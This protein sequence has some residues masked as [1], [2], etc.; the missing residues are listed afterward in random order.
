M[1]GRA[2][3][4]S[5]VEVTE[6]VEVLDGGELERIQ[7][8]MREVVR[9]ASAREGTCVYRGE[10][11]C[12]CVVSSRLYRQCPNSENEAF[13]MGRVEQEMAENARQYTTVA[14]DGEILTEIQYFGGA[15]NLID[16]T[17]DYLVAL[18]FASV[19]G[20]GKDGR[21]VLHWPESETMV[22]PKQ[23]ISRVV[24]QK[25][26]FVRP[27]RGFIVPDA[28]DET[29]VVPGNLKASLLS[30]LE[31]F[32]GISERTVYNDIHGF[33]GHQTPS[34]S[35]YAREFPGSRERTR[36]DVRGDLKRCLAETRVDICVMRMRHA[37]H[38]RAMVY[39]SDENSSLFFIKAIPTTYEPPMIT[40]PFQL[41]AEE[42][43]VLFTYFIEENAHGVELESVYCGRGEAH[44]YQGA[45]DLAM[46]DFD[47]ALARD[48]EMAVAYHGR[49][50]AY[51]QQG[52]ADRAMA[53]W[54]K[55]LRLKPDLPAAL[56]DRG[57]AHREGAALEEA[58]R[59]F[60]A[61]IAIMD[62][63]SYRE[64]TGIGDGQFYRAVARC[65]QADWL[66]AKGDLEAARQ[67]GVLV[68][69][70][71][72]NIYGDVPG[73]EARY[74][75]RVPS[76]VKTMLHVPNP[77]TGWWVCW[78]AGRRNWRE[79]HRRIKVMAGRPRDC[80]LAMAV[81]SAPPNA[82][83]RVRSLPSIKKKIAGSTGISRDLPGCDPWWGQRLTRI[84]RQH[85][86]VPGAPDPRSALRGRVSRERPPRTTKP[87]SRDDLVHTGRPPR[88]GRPSFLRRFS[89]DRRNR[90][91]STE[92]PT[93][94]PARSR[95]AS[96]GA[97]GWRRGQSR[98]NPSRH[99]LGK[100]LQIV[101]PTSAIPGQRDDPG[102]AKIDGSLTPVGSNDFRGGPTYQ[103]DRADAE[104]NATALGGWHRA[105]RA[106]DRGV[107]TRR[108][109]R[110][111]WKVPEYSGSKFWIDRGAALSPRSSR[112]QGSV[113]RV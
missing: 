93:L 112:A 60:D 67:A 108:T 61:A 66:G 30:F 68:A 21:V 75:V 14:D 2:V 8:V 23:T 73:F 86:A 69:S 63:G 18:F 87:G 3:A 97:T 7:G 54:E 33:I 46:R 77:L 101:G 37:H 71:F 82:R 11:E 5:G 43:V 70:S 44:L 34:R 62:M 55:A 35:R 47:E 106:V 64:L 99:D 53:D 41:S 85:W 111:F 15:T 59:D 76:V 51:W 57:N 48:A 107:R 9:K 78:L 36:R 92:N 4:A 74:D 38:Q 84:G 24:S 26:V 56:I 95:S 83:R 79:G 27:R 22:T 104:F 13:D 12:Y 42:A 113:V 29:V 103:V 40:Y 109:F 52:R 110:L 45:T 32:H 72:R 100:C 90:L 28:R 105:M 88:L 6:N 25:S 98:A 31:R 50:N 19:E 49:G 89:R 58:I 94:A 20:D 16:F 80:S 91:K 39:A 102:S 96:I 17:D 65:V 10:P 1:E 81:M